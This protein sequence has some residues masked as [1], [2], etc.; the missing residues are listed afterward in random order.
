M[1]HCFFGNMLLAA[2]AVPEE[3]LV[4]KKAWTGIA[5]FL[6]V[7]CVGLGFWTRQYTPGPV[8]RSARSGGAV[9][10][11]PLGRRQGEP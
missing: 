5:G 11:G 2:P 9:K 4:V 7:R 6:F 1:R 8:T 3:P 10:A